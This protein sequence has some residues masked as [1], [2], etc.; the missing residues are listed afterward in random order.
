MTTAQLRSAIY[1]H[2]NSQIPADHTPWIDRWAE[3]E[4]NPL[5]TELPLVYSDWL[6]E[7]GT[8][9]AAS[10]ANFLR[11]E[12]KARP[13]QRLAE[14][15]TR[16]LK[17]D[18]A[19]L[20]N[21]VLDHGTELSGWGSIRAAKDR[22]RERDEAKDGIPA[23]DQRLPRPESVTPEMARRRVACKKIGCSARTHLFGLIATT[24]NQ[25]KE[26]FRRL[27][28]GSARG[29]QAYTAKPST[30]TSRIVVKDKGRYSNS[31]HYTKYDRSLR[32]RSYLVASRG[33]KALYVL[34][35]AE[36][37]VTLPSGYRWNSD[38]NGIFAERV[39]DGCD[40]HPTSEELIQGGDA[41]V[42][43]LERHA[44]ARIVAKR[45][46]RRLKDQD[47]ADVWVCFKDSRRAG[48]CAAG[49]LSF[50]D[51]H[52]LSARK[53]YRADKLLAIANGNER[54]VRLAVAVAA[55]RHELEQQRGYCL[56]REHE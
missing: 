25:D 5:D 31:C 40:Y 9:E 42:A 53:H 7:Q 17:G 2:F 56:L 44:D 6:E 12:H 26:I 52:G 18:Y 14:I 54:Q 24:E 23:S 16:R 10:L 36:Y 29:W 27:N 38:D 4:C 21:T 3:T 35:N 46:E 45:A 51:R 47:L 34:D 19:G 15:E 39:S 20:R 43:E 41:I 13:E 50:T 49:T 11:S 28:N 37:R 1:R 8:E 30:G 55:K 33:R 32:V 48:N 22:R